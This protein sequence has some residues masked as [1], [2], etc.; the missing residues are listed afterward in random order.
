MRAI[1]GGVYSVFGF[2]NLGLLMGDDCNQRACAEQGMTKVSLSE[3]SSSLAR[4]EVGWKAQ[5]HHRSLQ[6]R[7]GVR[8]LRR[9][10]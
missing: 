8:R 1:S 3:Q 9:S 4:C 5:T 7:L 2:R 6:F 10:E